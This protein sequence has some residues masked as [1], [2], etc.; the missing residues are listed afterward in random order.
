MAR[1]KKIKSVKELEEKISEY[2]KE[3]DSSGKPYTLSGLAVFIGV[4][5]KTLLNYSKDERF[6][7]AIKKAKAACEAY[8]EERLYGKG[9]VAGVIFSLKNNFGWTDSQEGASGS[10]EAA[11]DKLNEVFG[12]FKEESGK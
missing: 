1:P 2:F 8:A 11:A 5:R 9:Q 10:D 4:D 3:C 6:F 7:P 12:L